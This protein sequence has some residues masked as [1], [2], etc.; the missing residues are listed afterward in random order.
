M[1]NIHNLFFKKIRKMGLTEC[2]GRPQKLQ[3][4][5]NKIAE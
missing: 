5:K 1:A 3:K 2:I 4:L